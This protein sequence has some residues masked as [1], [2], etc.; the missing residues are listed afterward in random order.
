MSLAARCPHCQTVFRI[1]GAQLAAAQGWVRCGHCAQVFDAASNLATPEGH[2]LEVPT[3]DTAVPLAA[4]SKPA[5]SPSATEPLANPNLQAL[6]DID[7]EL[8]DLGPLKAEAQATAL[9]AATPPLAAQ[10]VD[11]PAMAPPTGSD[12]TPT[13][14]V[15][16]PPR[17]L[18]EPFW[19][20]H[21]STPAALATADESPAPLP[22]SRP[23]PGAWWAV[24][25]LS[26]SLVVLGAYAMRAQLAYAWPEA[27]PVV[28]QLCQAIGCTLPPLRLINAVLIEGSS[29]SYDDEAAVHRLR[30]VVRHQGD[31]PAQMP[32][33]DLSL[34]DENRQVLARRMIDPTEFENP[35]AVL[36]RGAETTLSLVLNL[37]GIEAASI[38]SF[39]VTPY[40]P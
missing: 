15:A 8:P 22:T 7:L 10:S 28:M 18:R 31:W 14:P 34:L 1:T 6:P 9:P 27:R 16:P 13:A 3:V 17:D 36:D 32:A 24:V 21:Q 29:L 12:T 23:A 11:E 38:G 37:R 26:V 25:A 5:A 2:P 30:L 20:D 39:Q 33:F 35:Q 4:G 19:T 40:Y